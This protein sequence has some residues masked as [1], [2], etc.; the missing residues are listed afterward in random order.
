MDRER[1]GL[2]WLFIGLVSLMLLCLALLGVRE[3]QNR[4]AARERIRAFS[5]RI[6]EEETLKKER[7]GEVYELLQGVLS[8]QLPRIV[9]LGD[10]YMAGNALGS[11]PFQLFR[12]VNQ[13]LFGEIN[14]EVSFYLRQMNQ[15]SI[16]LPVENR[17]VVEESMAMVLARFGGNEMLL[18]EDLTLPRKADPVPVDFTDPFGDFLLAATQPFCHFGEVTI[19]EAAGY[20]YHTGDKKDE[21]H[22]QTAFRSQE[23]LVEELFFPAGT[24]VHLSSQEDYREDVLVVFFGNNAWESIQNWAPGHTG[25]SPEKTGFA[26]LEE[27]QRYVEGIER[28]LKR[29]TKQKLPAVVLG[30]AMEGSELDLLYQETFGQRYVRLPEKKLSQMGQDDFARAAREAFACLEEQ[31]CFAGVREG[32]EQALA[33]WKREMG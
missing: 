15:T 23:P 13:E 3:R 28:I 1:P 7:A 26:S 11:L 16:K 12:L 10:D 17:G 8:E 25:S 27:R 20:L 4:L 24:E 32:V 22:Y 21:V 19:G 9:C 6:A 30:C 14:G 5:Q 31:G 33:L 18:K 2:D 29:R